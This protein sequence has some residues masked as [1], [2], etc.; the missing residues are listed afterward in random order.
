MVKGGFTENDTNGTCAVHAAVPA[1]WQ[2]GRAAG[3]ASLKPPALAEKKKEKKKSSVTEV[4]PGTRLSDA[5]K[6]VEK[7]VERRIL[8]ARPLL[9]T[10]ARCVAVKALLFFSPSSRE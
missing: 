10:T 9:A 8:C 4:S 5:M 1:G 3:I 7:Y 2:K 6:V